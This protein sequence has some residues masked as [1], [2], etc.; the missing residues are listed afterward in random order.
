MSTK[1]TACTI[2]N[3][4]NNLDSGCNFSY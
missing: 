3:K 2:N 1:N 4:P